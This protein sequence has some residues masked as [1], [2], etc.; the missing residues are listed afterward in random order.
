M[1]RDSSPLS[2]PPATH[3]PIPRSLAFERSWRIIDWFPIYAWIQHFIHG[4]EE[5]IWLLYN[6]GTLNCRPLSS[7]TGNQDRQDGQ[8]RQDL[9][10]VEVPELSQSI[11]CHGNQVWLL[12][13]NGELYHRRQISLETPQGIDWL[14]SFINSRFVAVLTHLTL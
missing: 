14:R 12:L 5:Y 13:S 3:T 11:C 2:P 8:D 9:V 10:L 4:I 1:F 6:N 7:G